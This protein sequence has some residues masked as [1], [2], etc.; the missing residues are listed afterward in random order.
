[1]AQITQ[2]KKQLGENKQTNE[3]VKQVKDDLIR[4]QIEGSQLKTQIKQLT[5]ENREKDAQIQQL[6][7][8]VKVLEQQQASG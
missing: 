8:Y 3:S 7:S 6:E 1:M 5:V 4:Q 2:L